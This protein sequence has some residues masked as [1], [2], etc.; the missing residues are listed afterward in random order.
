MEGTGKMLSGKDNLKM[1]KKKELI[2]KV[3]KRCTL[4]DKKKLTGYWRSA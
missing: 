1:R 3:F 4:I 2:G